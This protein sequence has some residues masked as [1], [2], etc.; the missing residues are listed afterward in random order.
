MVM[1]PHLSNPALSSPAPPTNTVVSL[2]PDGV[3]VEGQK[4]IITCQSDG[5]PPSALV[6][7]KEGVELNRTD[8]D[9]TLF[10][11]FTPVKPEDSASYQCEASNQYGSQVVS[12]VLWVTG[13]G[14]SKV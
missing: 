7:R 4:V 2:S 1:P 8:S 10:F 9:S 5:A 3:I 12:T 13:E 14:T 11:S 6:L